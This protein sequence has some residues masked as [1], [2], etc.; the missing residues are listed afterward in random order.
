MSSRVFREL[1]QQSERRMFP[2]SSFGI[3]FR[4]FAGNFLTFLVISRKST[5]FSW[6]G[7]LSQV[8]LSRS[9]A[10]VFGPGIPVD[11]RTVIRFLVFGSLELKAEDDRDLHSVLKH[12]KHAA[13]LAYL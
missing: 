10:Y 3:P 5:E 2:Y 1:E 12:S 6:V 9:E 13:L 8:A 4:G 7:G 11:G